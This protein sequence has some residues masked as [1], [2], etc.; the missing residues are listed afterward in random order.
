[1][2]PATRARR[3][4][5]ERALVFGAGLPVASNTRSA[6]AR[7]RGATVHAHFPEHPHYER[8]LRQLP[9][10][11]EQTGIHVEAHTTPY[12]KMRTKQAESL[13]RAEGEIDLL[14]YLILWKTEYAQR[15]WL[16]ELQ[17]LLDDGA[18]ALPGFALAGIVEPYLQ[19]IGLVGGP[20]GYLPGP[21]ARL[22]GLPCGAETS[23]LLSRLD[24]LQRHGLQ[25]P[26]YYDDLLAACRTIAEQ[27]HIAGLA[28]RGLAGHH[29]TH[30]WL[31]HLTPHAGALF[32]AQW[33]CLLERPQ[34]QRATA[35]LR[36]VA[37]TGLREMAQ[38]GFGEM[39]AAF[40]EGRAAFYL[41][42]TSL[43]GVLREARHADLVRRLHFAMHPSG[44][45]LS[46]QIGGF[47]LGIAGNARQPQAAWMLMQWLLS[48]AVDLTIGLDG[49][50]PA[51]WS[52]LS[53]SGFR[54]ARPEMSIMQFALRA[55]NP[56]WRP[57]IPEWDAISQDILG[58]T[59]PQ[60]VFGQGDIAAGHAT[61]AREVEALLRRSGRR[62]ERPPVR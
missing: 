12:L 3:R 26:L 62:P 56:D 18:L 9:R 28:S 48:P 31:L 6:T 1:M 46:G 54:T 32:D 15:G 11:T 19:S 47:G 44:T 40:L 42:S 24:L 30:A 50:V 55:A 51:R 16:H 27:D 4:F 5:V 43:L 22:V 35:V 38:A 58:R 17:P 39:Q 10:F 60:L 41:D 57:L 33:N 13:A 25:P 14:G 2:I 21:G 20:R 61:M 29:I 45:R 52:T 59:L 49:G 23:V 37:Q 36:E 53:D 7:L 8:V 34:A